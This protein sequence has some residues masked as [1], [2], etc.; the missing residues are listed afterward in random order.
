MLTLLTPVL[1]E[2]MKLF[3]V[4][5]LG[6]AGVLGNARDLRS[7][8]VPGKVLGFTPIRKLRALI[9]ANTEQQMV[10][11][12]LPRASLALFLTQVAWWQQSD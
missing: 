10:I 8:L 6:D 4:K 5:V 11:S 12:N 9:S 3:F 7:H 2:Q 1:S